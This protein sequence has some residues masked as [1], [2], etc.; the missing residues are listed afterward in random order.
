MEVPRSA[1]A[2]LVQ[3]VS[4][5]FLIELLNAGQIGYRTVGSHR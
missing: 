1:L 3:S 4:R 2:A 5:P